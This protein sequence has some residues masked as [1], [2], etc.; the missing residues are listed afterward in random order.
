MGC[1][2][3]LFLCFTNF[4]VFVG[5]NWLM[6]TLQSFQGKKCSVV[7]CHHLPLGF[8]DWFPV[9]ILSRG[10]PALVVISDK[11]GLARA[12]VSLGLTKCWA[13]Y[14]AAITYFTAS[15]EGNSKLVC[16]EVNPSLFEVG[17][18]RLKVLRTAA[19]V[20]LLMVNSNEIRL[21]NMPGWLNITRK[22]G[23]QSFVKN[24]MEFVTGT[25]FFFMFRLVRILPSSSY[26]KWKLKSSNLMWCLSS[27]ALTGSHNQYS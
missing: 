24:K 9:Q 22:N 2:C 25:N 18:S 16:L 19:P 1:S 17:Y 7:I 15:I 21:E 4:I 8:L 13:V 5:S 26:W 6:A 12:I 3:W 14:E 23:L 10:D 27:S 11:I 20:A